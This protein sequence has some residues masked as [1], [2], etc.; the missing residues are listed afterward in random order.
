M[1]AAAIRT[2]PDFSSLTVN[3]WLIVASGKTPTISPDFRYF[4]AVRN[5]AVPDSR[6]TGM[7]CMPRI[8]GP[9]TLSRKTPSL[10]MNRVSRRPP[11]HGASPAKMKSR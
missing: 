7:W 1:P 11:F 6:S 9:P 2:A 8:S 3:D 5:E 4:S 10:A